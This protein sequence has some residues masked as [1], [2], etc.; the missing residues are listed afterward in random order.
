MIKKS[1]QA[2]DTVYFV[3]SAIFV[4]KA[5]VI[6]AT[7]DFCTIKFDD[8]GGGIRVRNSKLYNS[9]EGAEAVIAMNKRMGK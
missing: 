5:T 6:R 1:Y 9:K 4:R 7:Q 8:T 3:S 2:G